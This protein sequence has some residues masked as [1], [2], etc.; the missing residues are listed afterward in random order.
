MADAYL[1]DVL[2]P[3]Y[4]LLKELAGFVLLK[5]F[6]FHDVIEQL[7]S[8]GI[9]HDQKQLSLGLNYLKGYEF[10]W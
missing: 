4:N 5:P 10:M 8:A 7:S 9:L 3:R 1:V 2:D 6:S